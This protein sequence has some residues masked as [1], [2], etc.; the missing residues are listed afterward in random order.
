MQACGQAR[1]K[2]IANEDQY[3]ELVMG[4]G[5]DGDD[6][7]LYKNLAIKRNVKVPEL[8]N[9]HDFSRIWMSWDNKKIQVCNILFFQVMIVKPSTA[10]FRNLIWY[11]RKSTPISHFE[12]MK[13]ERAI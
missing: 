5:S 2:L 11:T 4:G 9:C 6:V 7:L 3:Y 13:T 1:I 10:V 12:T 8:L